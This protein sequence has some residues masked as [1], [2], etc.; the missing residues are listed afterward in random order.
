[1]NLFVGLVLF[2]VDDFCFRCCPATETPAVPGG[3]GVFVAPCELETILPLDP[4][5]LLLCYFQVSSVFLGNFCLGLVAVRFFFVLSSWPSGCLSGSRVFGVSF[6]VRFPGVS[7]SCVFL[8]AFRL[9]GVFL[10]LRCSL[11]SCIFLS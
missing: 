9:S 3:P 8:S 6:S 11:A 1:M 7:S 2:V 4:Y 5:I 10:A